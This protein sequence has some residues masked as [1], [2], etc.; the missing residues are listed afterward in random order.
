MANNPAKPVAPVTPINVEDIFRQAVYFEYATNLLQRE[1]SDAVRNAIETKAPNFLMPAF[2]PS[3]ALIPFSLE[4]YLK[5]LLEIDKC[6]FKKPKGH[7]LVYLFGCTRP[8]RQVRVRQLYQNEVDNDPASAILIAETNEPDAFSFDRVLQ[9][10]DTAFVHWRYHHEKTAGSPSHGGFG[11]GRIRDAVRDTI[12][13]IHPDWRAVREAFFNR[14][15]SSTETSGIS[16][17]SA[18]FCE[19]ITE[20]AGTVYS[21]SR[22]IDRVDIRSAKPLSEA[23]PCVTLRLMIVLRSETQQSV[24]LRL[25]CRSPSG[26]TVM[27]TS[28][29]GPIAGGGRMTTIPLTVKLTVE[30]TGRYWFNILFNDKSITKVPLL[31]EYQQTVQ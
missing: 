30:E 17:A 23:K 15:S 28:I 22:I 18:L 25:L 11:S 7:E 4:L 10:A 8:D 3:A 1:N 9:G 12:L 20:G 19:E 27:D 29:P 2:V 14:I 6:T 21:L 26:K 24:I 31:V 13:E 16:V 5:C